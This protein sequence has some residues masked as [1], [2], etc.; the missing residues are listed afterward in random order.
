MKRLLTLIIVILVAIT[1]NASKVVTRTFN[2]TLTDGRTVTVQ[3]R[4]DENCHYVISDT[5]EIIIY[6]NGT[7]RVA[8]ETEREDIFKNAESTEFSLISEAKATLSANYP[9]PHIG[10]PKVLVIMVNFTDATFKYTRDDIDSLLNSK[11]YNTSIG[12][13]SYG[14]AAQF[15]EDCSGGKF[16][17]QFDVVGPYNLSHNTPYYGGGSTD[18]M[19]RL[20]PDACSAAD[21]DVD[22]TQYDSNSDGKI[23]LVY[24][25]YAGYGENWSGGEY[26]YLLYP[27]S[28]YS[29]KYGTFDGK[30]VFRYAID[31]ELVGYPGIEEELEMDKS[32][33]N[34]IGV[35]VHEM[36]HTM[37]LPDF[38][39]KSAWTDVSW[40]DNQSMEEWD[41]MDG[42]ENI[43]NGYYPAPF[44]AWE[45]ELFDWDTIDT[46]ST[47]SDVTLKSYFQGGK[48]LRIM[49]DNDISENEYYILESIPTGSNYSWYRKMPGEGLLI[50]HVNYSRGAFANFNSPNNE[51]GKP[52]ITIL[53][54]DGY[55]PS[56]Y[57][58]DTKE[59]SADY[60]SDE[61]FKEELKGDTYPGFKNVC[62]LTEWKAYTGTLDKPLTDISY[63]RGVVK[64]KFMG[65]TPNTITEVKNS[66]DNNDIYSMDGL[67]HGKDP[68]VLSHGIY[69]I[70]GK[71]IIK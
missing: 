13:H 57:R 26:S 54:A 6:D 45:R 46:L 60:L 8:T 41:L 12:L 21:A 36:S 43:Y 23:D 67:Y 2:V 25:L 49:N 61:A 35:F 18:Y 69:I 55:L 33:L 9:F 30:Q 4:G 27:R 20:I 58:C 48:A 14:S 44:S 16:R 64:F 32:Y 63:S 24:V 15:F 47:P 17:P 66:N 1:M 37:G 7:W 31:A 71:K 68:S 3:T 5:N 42:G 70:N 56:S 11:T 28:G 50:T 38:Y 65:G 34:G 40:Y 22:F 19:E 62:S 52:C 53:P 51:H 39:P 29:S 59:S 10:T